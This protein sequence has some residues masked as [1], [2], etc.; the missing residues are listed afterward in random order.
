MG[1]HAYAYRGQPAY[2]D[3]EKVCRT[4]IYDVD[5][6]QRTVIGCSP[7]YDT[8]SY[9]VET[10]VTER[11]LSPAI[12]TDH[13]RR[14][15]SPTKKTTNYGSYG[16]YDKYRR[17]SS[18]SYYDRRPQE[19]NDFL[20]G[21]QIEASRPNNTRYTLPQ[22][23]AA[24]GR[25]TAYPTTGYGGGYG[26]Y[27]N[28]NNYGGYS[29]DEDDGED[30]YYKPSV[31]K[32][33]SEPVTPIRPSPKTY[34]TEGRWSSPPPPASHGVGKLSLPTNNVEEAIDY[35]KGGPRTETMKPY[36]SNLKTTGPAIK[37]YGYG[38]E[39]KSTDSVK[40]YGSNVKIGTETA[41]PYGS[42]GSDLKSNEYVNPHGYEPDVKSSESV[43]PYGTYGSDY[44][45]SESVRPYG[46]G[47]DLKSTDAAKPYGTKYPISSNATSQQVIDCYEAARK[48]N[49]KVIRT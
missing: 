22:H 41:R 17:P 15:S 42:Y 21:V 33:R 40:P 24:L 30:A 3:D 48:Y 43:R 9:V 2:S 37:P 39:L 4:S 14:G 31:N 46:Y 16:S 23:G 19:V 47:S 6:R 45:S 11:V 20:T 7:F 44:K 13:Y 10:E 25:P 29:S 28:G 12:A 1:D 18:P 38:S 49:G 27:R 8:E 34:A 36:G 32:I 35:L 5:G 26:D